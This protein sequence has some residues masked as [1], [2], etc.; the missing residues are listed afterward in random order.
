MAVASQTKTNKYKLTLCNQRFCSCTNTAAIIIPPWRSCYSQN[1]SFYYLLN[2]SVI[3][4]V[5]FISLNTV[6]NIRISLVCNCRMKT[7]SGFESCQIPRHN[8]ALSTLRMLSFFISKLASKQ[9]CKY[10]SAS[11]SKLSFMSW[12]T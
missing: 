10:T 11:C 8:T 7:H 6:K 12:C 5:H 1:K 2:Y 9:V 3:F 4:C